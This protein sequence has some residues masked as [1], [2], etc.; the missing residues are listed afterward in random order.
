M[1]ADRR[2]LPRGVPA[3]LVGIDT[4]PLRQTRAG[5]ARY[6]R[7]LLDHL[8]VPVKEA[9]FPATSRLRTVAADVFWYP[10]LEVD[11]VD[12]L[13][14]PT[15][16]GPLRSKVPLIVTVHDLAVLRHPEWFNRWTRR[17]SAGAVPESSRPPTD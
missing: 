14:C 16:R 9:S 15:F 10:R 7:G 13:H 3:I 1:G 4:T 2:A 8:D 12:V 11:G 17:Y 6:L 5:T